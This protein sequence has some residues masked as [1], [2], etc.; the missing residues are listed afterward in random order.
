MK[1]V[2]IIHGWGYEPSDNWYPWLK[3]Q[4]IKVGFEVAVPEMP[5]A[6][7][8]E[9]GAWVKKLSEV[10]G[11]PDGDTYFIGHSIGCQT[12]MRYLQT[13]G[14]KVGGAVFVAGW[15]NLENLEDTEVEKVARPWI[16]TQIDF[17]KI[18]SVLPKSCLLISDNDPYGAFETNKSGFEKLGSKIVVLK[19]AGHI[20][21]EDGF[22]ELPQVLEGVLPL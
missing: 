22:T 2:F 21:K 1:R 18:K 5:S 14:V 10:V 20:T 3:D 17:E 19:N 4:L 6:D 11:A 16:E 13:T 12:I 8:P 9:I 15:F 7:E